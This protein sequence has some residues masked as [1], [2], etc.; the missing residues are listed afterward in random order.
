MTMHKLFSALPLIGF[1]LLTNPPARAQFQPEED[2]NT[3][4]SEE[5]VLGHNGLRYR[6]VRD[7]AKV[8]RDAAPVINAHAMVEGSDGRYY[9]VTD[10]PQ[11]AVV[12]FEADGTFVDAIGEGLKGG[13]GI[14]LI[15]V[16]GEELLVH[17]DCGWAFTAEGKPERLN[18]SINLL[19]K[20]GTVVRTL[21]SPKELGLIAEDDYYNPCDVA[22]TREGDLLVID[23]Y[24]TD[25]VFHYNA[26]G[27]LIRH[28]GGKR[29]K[30]DP[31]SIQNGHGIAIE[32][33]KDGGEPIV[34]VS[35]RSESKLKTFTL[36]GEH[37]S[38]IDLPGTF[39]GQPVL[40]DGHIY[41]GVCWSRREGVGERLSRSGFVVVLDRET[42]KVISAPGGTEPSYI[43]GELQPLFQDSDTFRHVHDLMID[44][45]GNLFVM[46]WNAGCRYPYKLELID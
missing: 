31:R 17:V 41:S 45:S 43:D 6:L 28:W 33:P 29:E 3:A 24:S 14:D 22:V 32:Y 4:T 16:D 38:T 12:V 34:W 18:G 7:W 9:L 11:N 1:V 23:G 21:P 25:R 37:L 10:H 8:D 42:G 46:E 5:V 40:H 35:S 39:P 30:G 15:T 19:R 2:A 20:D 13:H 36:E 27:E 44:A 26:E